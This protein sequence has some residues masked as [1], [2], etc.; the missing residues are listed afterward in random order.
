MAQACGVAVGVAGVGD[1]VAERDAVGG[2]ARQDG[3]Q[4]AGGVEVAGAEVI[5]RASSG[6]AG[7]FSSR[8]HDGGRQVVAEEHLALGAG[9]VGVAVPPGGLGV[10]AFGAAVPGRPGPGLD[11]G[12]VRGQRGARRC[13]CCG[14]DAGLQQLVADGLA[15]RADGAPSGCSLPSASLTRRKVCS[16][17]R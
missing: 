13:L 9:Q 2:H 11:V 15:G 4:G 7:P 5:R 6:T 3:D 14:G 10:G 12:P 8:D 1:D 17:C 16:T